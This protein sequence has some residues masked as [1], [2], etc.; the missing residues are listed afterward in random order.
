M[1]TEIAL[2]SALLPNHD[3]LTEDEKRMIKS[4]KQFTEAYETNNDEEMVQTYHEIWEDYQGRLYFK[5][6]ELK[7]IRKAEEK[8]MVRGRDDK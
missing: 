7:R 6:E 8:L 3:Y 4:S 2:A 1:A 5:P